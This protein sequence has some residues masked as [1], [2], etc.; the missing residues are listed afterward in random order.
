MKTAEPPKA[1]QEKAAFRMSCAVSCTIAAPPERIWAL[2]TNAEDFPRWNSTV[3]KVGGTIQLGEKLALEV[4]AAPGRTF[5]PKV[6]QLEPNRSMEWSD[7]FAPMFK[8]VRTFTLA[9]NA[10][11]STT[12]EMVE[13]FSGLMLPMIKGSLPDFG[14]SFEAYAADLKRE[15]EGKA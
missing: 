11:G 13:V 7:G 14:P 5:K 9:P 1:V 15:A 12:F 6:T 10:D 8:G 3:S 2:L 4:P